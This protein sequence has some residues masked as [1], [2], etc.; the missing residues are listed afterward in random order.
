MM[1]AGVGQSQRTNLAEAIDEASRIAMGST[2]LAKADLA[3]VFATVHYQSGFGELFETV[4]EVTG[5]NHV[6][7]CSAASVLTSAGEFEGEPAVAVLVLRSDDVTATPFLMSE[8]KTLD[9]GTAMREFISAE[10]R[11]NALLVVFPDVRCISP[12]SLIT[13]IG[14]DGDELPIVGAAPSSGDSA[15]QDAYEWYDNNIVKGSVAGVLLTG[16]LHTEI[17]VAQGCE[18][19]GPPLKITRAKENVIYEMDGEPAMDVLQKSLA[20]LTEQEIVKSGRVLFIGIAM[21]HDKESPRRGDFLIRSLVGFEKQT[22]AI[23]LS[24]QVHEGQVVQLHLRNRVAADEEIREIVADLYERT[25]E[26]TPVFGMYFNCLGRGKE[27]YGNKNHDI[28]IIQGKFPDMPII[29]FFGNAEFAP[30]G[31]RNF[32]H[33]YTGALVLCSEN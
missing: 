20:S 14:K 21:D 9:I 4:Q 1:R 12:E 23:A 16:R 7:G 5:C 11:E 8:S 33:A 22:A 27:M 18:P 30:I 25:R 3:I 15:E 26:H 13:Q 31:R 24:E 28:R 19:I 17:G 29:G 32:A 10:V 6:V 2:R